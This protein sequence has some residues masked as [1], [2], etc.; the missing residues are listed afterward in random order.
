[1]RR[2]GLALGAALI[3]GLVGGVALGRALSGSGRVPQ[4]ENAQA[5]VWRTRVATGDPLPLHRHD[6]PR[7]VVALHDG[8]L[9]LRDSGGAVE[10]LPIQFGHAYWLPAMAPGAMHQDVNPGREPL[11]LMVIELK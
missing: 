7:I 5:K 8:E 10:R 6:H 11:D 4:F 3:V 9:D 2:I 1:M